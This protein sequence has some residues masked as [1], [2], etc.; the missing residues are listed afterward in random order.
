[1]QALSISQYQV[2]SDFS[3]PY[4]RWRFTIWF[5]PTLQ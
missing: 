2:S 1:M 3:S 5:Q 4:I